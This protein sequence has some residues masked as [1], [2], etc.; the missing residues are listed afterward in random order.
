MSFQIRQYENENALILSGAIT[1]DQAADLHAALLPLALE[2]RPIAVEADTVTSVHTSILQMLL[3]LK[4]S[5]PQFD[6]RAVSPAFTDAM[7][8][9]GLNSLLASSKT[10]P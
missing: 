9:L 1:V 5:V 8:R 3:S 10:K 6:L 4:Q 7:A 2:A